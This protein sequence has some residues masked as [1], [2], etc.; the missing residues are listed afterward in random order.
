[1]YANSI[2][3]NTQPAKY[4]HY[5]TMQLMTFNKILYSNNL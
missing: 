5:V 4:I 3:T 1:M 2:Y